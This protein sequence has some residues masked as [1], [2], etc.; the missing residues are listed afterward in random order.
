MF[1]EQN[2]QNYN[3]INIDPGS[4]T[5]KYFFEGISNSE[6][7]EPSLQF[8]T[9]LLNYAGV[10]EIDTEFMKSAIVIGV[11]IILIIMFVSIVMLY[12]AFKMTYSERLK[13]LG[14]LSSIGMDKKQKKTIIR[15]EAIILG[16]I[17]HNYRHTCRANSIKIFN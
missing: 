3:G 1:L 11:T 4:L 2:T 14:M 6:N 17:R 12:T 9:E 13:E 10:L 16:I 5:Y 8:N 15:K 7:N